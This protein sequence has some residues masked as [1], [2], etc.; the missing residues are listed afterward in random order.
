MRD[1]DLDLCERLQP[2]RPA[3][4]WT[5]VR[6]EVWFRTDFGGACA[7]R[8]AIDGVI[9]TPW[10]SA[11]AIR[12]GGWRPGRT[13]QSK[14][15]SGAWDASLALGIAVA[16]MPGGACGHR[17][18]TH[19]VAP[20]TPSP[21]CSCRSSS[22]AS[23]SSPR[24]CRLAAR[25]ACRRRWRCRASDRSP[26]LA[27]TGSHASRSH[28]HHSRR[29]RGGRHARA[30]FARRAGAR[31]RAT[32]GVHPRAGRRARGAEHP[33]TSQVTAG[34]RRTQRRSA[35]GAFLPE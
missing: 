18:A 27:E 30:P 25:R 35:Y 13:R 14:F 21:S 16:W 28:H 26:R 20:W 33:S 1:V 31:H 8:D 15:C 5:P 2:L 6:G 3:C 7:R 17:Q 12:A 24:T 29:P 23:R 19:G 10:R 9:R 4:L 22:A 32:A 11:R 34:R